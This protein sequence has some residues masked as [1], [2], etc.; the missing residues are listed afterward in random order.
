MFSVVEIILLTLLMLIIGYDTYHTQILVYGRS[1]FCGFFAGLI[2]GDVTTGLLIGGTL[3]LMSLGVGTYGG[4]SVPNYS[5]G[6]IIGVAFAVQLGGGMDAGLAVGI[7]AAALG[8]QLDVFAKMAGSFFLRKAQECIETLEL[9]KMYRWIL[10]GAI[11]RVGFC[12]LTVFVAL[13]AGSSVIQALL[14]KMPEWL[15]VGLNVAGGMLP[16]VG[17]AILLRFM[18][19]KKYF[20]FGILGFVLVSYLQ[21]PMIGIALI[22]FVAAYL[23]YNQNEKFANLT[24]SNVSAIRG[25]QYDE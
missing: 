2:M 9:K 24:A 6:S 10:L 1:I 19:L 5:V 7:P 22:G 8:V 20:V 11:P 13:T 3:E 14:D 17:F 12:A 16:A 15:S 18:P 21:L 23:I 4:S 25:D